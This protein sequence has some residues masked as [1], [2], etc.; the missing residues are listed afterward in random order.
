MST[1]NTIR[2]VHLRRA[3]LLFAIVLAMAALVASLSRPLDDRRGQTTTPA[4]PE[5]GP[6]TASP[7]PAT[8]DSAAEPRTLRFHGAKS[9]SKP[10]QANEAAT[11]EVA[12]AEAGSVEIPDLGLT[13]PA[14]PD[15]PAR[16]DVLAIR[17]GRYPLLFT[18]A[19]EHSPEPAG[20]LVVRSRG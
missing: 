17:P 1:R 4:E 15:T 3:L 13:A 9:Q 16:F 20:S 7:A 12:V 5:P 14:D 18:P 11:V 19:G 10:L 8:G 6:E 2:A